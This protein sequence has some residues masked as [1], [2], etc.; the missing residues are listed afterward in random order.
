MH[1]LRTQSRRV[2]L[3]SLRR[4]LLPFQWAS[5]MRF[6]P[7]QH[8][9]GVVRERHGRR[10][11][12]QLEFLHS[13]DVGTSQLLLHLRCP[14]CSWENSTV[15]MFLVAVWPAT[16]QVRGHE[17]QPRPVWRCLASSSHCAAPSVSA[18]CISDVIAL[19]SYARDR[20]DM[21]SQVLRECGVQ[22]TLCV[23]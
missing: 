23:L 11:S 5:S 15:V 10:A 14:D 8:V 13:S 21:F 16:S 22:V 12:H 20:G 6:V 17:Q 9:V 18:S 2:R 4:M 19:P 3:L 7:T 1:A